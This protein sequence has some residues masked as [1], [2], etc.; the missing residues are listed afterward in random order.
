MADTE[1]KLQEH[2]EKE[3]EKKGLNHNWKTTEGM[4]V[5]KR[6][7]PRYNLQTGDA[8]IKQ[9]QKFKHLCHVF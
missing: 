2:P 1:R 3:S 8:E 5:R 9:T 4:V 6:N 7:I